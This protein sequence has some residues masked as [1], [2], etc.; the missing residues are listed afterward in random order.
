MAKGES[1]RKAKGYREMTAFFS[2]AAETN[3]TEAEL[4][5]DNIATSEDIAA[6]E[7]AMREWERGEAVPIDKS[8]ES[9]RAQKWAG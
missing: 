3:E 8:A 9:Q 4:H 5:S 6:H 2:K 1:Q 7:Q